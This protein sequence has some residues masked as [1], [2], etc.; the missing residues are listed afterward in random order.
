MA[1]TTTIYMLGEDYNDCYLGKTYIPG[2]IPIAVYSADECARVYS[3]KHDCD[4]EEA[5]EGWLQETL[6]GRII[7]VEEG[8]P[9]YVGLRV[10]H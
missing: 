7:F 2:G 8:L 1:E 5:L 9:E 6:E 4:V 10:V 3:E